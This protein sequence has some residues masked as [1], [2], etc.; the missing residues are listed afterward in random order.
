LKTTQTK[1]KSSTNQKPPFLWFF[2]K[3]KKTQNLQNYFYIKKF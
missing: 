1:Q 3:L 2:K